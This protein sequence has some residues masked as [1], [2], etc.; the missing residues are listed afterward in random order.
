MDIE[1]FKKLIQESE[2][3]FTDIFDTI[4]YRKNF[5]DYNKQLWCE[6]IKQIFK[7][8][9]S[10]S[11]IIKIRDNVEKSL[12]EKNEKKGCSPEFN[13]NAF[14][15]EI[16]YK[17][18]IKVDKETFK[19]KATDIEIDIEFNSQFLFQDTLKLLEYAHKMHKKIYCI[20]DMYLTKDMILELFRKHG[21]ESLFTD[22]YV[23]SEYLK[24]KIDGS[25]YRYVKLQHPNLHFDKC[26]MMGDNHCYDFKNATREGFN[27]QVIDRSYLYGHYQNLKDNVLKKKY[28]AKLSN[29]SEYY[30]Y[31]DDELFN[32]YQLKNI[33]Y[34]IYDSEISEIKYAKENESII[35]R[36]KKLQNELYLHR[37][38]KFTISENTNFNVK[39]D[40]ISFNNKEYYIKPFNDNENC[41]M[42]ILKCL[43]NIVDDNVNI[44]TVKRVSNKDC[45]DIPI[46]KLKNIGKNYTP[47]FKDYLG[48]I[49]NDIQ[50]KNIKKIYFFTREGEF[51][52]EVFDKIND[53]KN[54]TSYLLEVSRVATFFPSLNSIDINELK[55]LWSQYSIQSLSSLF[56]SLNLDINR[57]IDLI[58]KHQ[59]NIND[60]I[61]NPVDNVNLNNLFNDK[62]FI[63]LAMDDLKSAKSL[64]K[65]Y[66]KDRNF[67][68]NDEKVAIVDIG[69]RGTI[70]DNICYIFPNTTI[71]GYYFGLEKFLNK[72]PN[73]AYK[74]GYINQYYGKGKILGDVTPLEMLCNSCNGSTLG[75]EKNDDGVVQAIRKIDE[76]EN[77]SFYNCTKYIQEGIIENAGNK[78]IDVSKAYDVAVDIIYNPD[79]YVALTYFNLKHNEEFGLGEYVS[80][81]AYISKKE[82]INGIYRWRYQT[83]LK[84]KLE[85]TTWPYGYLVANDLMKYKDKLPLKKIGKNDGVKCKKRIAWIMPD[86]LEGSGGHR[87]IISNANYLVTR[88]YQCD[89]YFNDDY[90][91]TSDQLTEKIEKYFGECKC[92]V[93]VG[94]GL[95]MDYDMIFATYSVITP[96]IVKN[97]N[98]EHKMYFVQDFEPWFDAMGD[99]YIIKENSYKEGFR[100]ISIGNWL[101]HKIATECSGKISSFPFCADLSIYKP[102]NIEKE[103]AICFIF[104]PDKPRRCVELGLRALKLVKAI[105]PN[106]K[107]YLY[108]SKQKYYVD[109]EH[110]NLHIISL[111]ECNKLYNKC[112]VGLCISSSNPSRIPFEMM[113]A[114]LPVVDLYRENNLYDMPDEGV[115]LAYSNPQSIATTI[116]NLLDDEKLAKEK[117]NYGIKYMQKY[118]INEGYKAFGDTVDRIFDGNDIIDSNIEQTYKTLPAPIREDVKKF[119]FILRYNPD[120]HD[121]TDYL[122]KLVVVKRKIKAKISPR[123]YL[124]V[125]KRGIKKILLMPAR[126]IKKILNKIIRKV[127]NR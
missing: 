76:I 10:L 45:S 31:F 51:F 58:I 23:S 78:D 115:T 93:F 43:T 50:K 47:L 24:N 56:K 66:F 5:P 124:R 36:L 100:M 18:N 123:R 112:K 19:K 122:R 86:L 90:V 110:E 111:E 28:L 106:I 73:N 109:F 119:E 79:K 48:W 104:Q 30:N 98:C 61:I 32:Y 16:Y 75:Y 6:A 105:K 125:I 52:K 97:S 57:Y 1:L 39:D 99:G 26:L 63:S 53:N 89:L 4:I 114:G 67:I 80:K 11:K 37:F 77:V 69:W 84:H 59:L 40:V 117:S 83:A 88:G 121:S 102:L 60:Q 29:V 71:Y 82:I 70:Q 65:E 54:I 126:I 107:I 120:C 34:D 9:I 41:F 14:L 108:G 74:Y 12:R 113:A 95:R 7:L 116:L 92:N 3:I 38:I 62:E 22:I 42:E 55:R 81:K 96:E 91:T 25:L 68:D 35:S 17:L 101:E 27:G 72:Q 8:K 15:E 46:D 13:Y 127:L 103:D 85:Q 20:S 33:C 44:K 87:T 64:L 2:A 49:L 94:L 118:D 21:I